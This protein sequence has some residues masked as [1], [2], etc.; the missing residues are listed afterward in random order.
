[1]MGWLPINASYVDGSI[2]VSLSELQH[3][4]KD[5]LIRVEQ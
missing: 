1:M 4:A 2:T 3:S 5:L